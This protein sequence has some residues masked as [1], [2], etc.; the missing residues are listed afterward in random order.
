MKY[1]IL[2]YCITLVAAGITSS[3]VR[4]GDDN[5]IRAV[6]ISTTKASQPG[7]VTVH[8][9]KCGDGKSLT[10]TSYNLPANVIEN[11]GYLGI[12]MEP[13]STNGVKIMDVSRGSAAMKAGLR[14]GDV[15]V[16]VNNQAV[17][18]TD[19]VI[20]LLSD[21][22]PGDNVVVT[23]ER[24][25]TTSTVTATLGKRATAINLAGV[26]NIRNIQQYM[27]KNINLGDLDILATTTETESATENPCERLKELNGT[28]FLGIWIDQARSG[29]VYLTGTLE[30]T[31]AQE[32]GLQKDDA[33]TQIAGKTVTNFEESRNEIR[34]HKPGEVVSVT[35]IRN[36][37]TKTV[38]ARLVS[39]GETKKEL[40][41]SLEARCAEQPAPLDVTKGEPLPLSGDAEIVKGNPVEVEV[42]VEPTTPAEM[43]EPVIVKGQPIEIDNEIPSTEIN[44]VTTDES[45]ILQVSPNPATGLIQLNFRNT[46][47][48]PFTINVTDANGRSV[49]EVKVPSHSGDYNAPMDLTKLPRGMYVVSIQQGDAI[50][51]TKVILQ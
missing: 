32:A 22:K 41:R 36:G 31:G 49:M 33:I 37:E 21:K 51:K 28:A 24:R 29:K 19:D 11:K 20:K 39:I 4:A 6:N 2:F 25:G 10:T 50:H 34:S 43:N 14:S 44:A 1:R 13:S 48:T 8:T 18:S 27:P 47:N 5:A 30:N 23:F 42:L 40:V 12:T 15:V 26:E 38:Q 16:S 9:V 46:E 3:V 17:Q 45:P 7:T 35:F